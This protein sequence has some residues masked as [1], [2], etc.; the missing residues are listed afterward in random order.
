MVKLEIN[1]E[2]KE[3]LCVIFSCIAVWFAVWAFSGQFPWAANPYNSYVLQAKAWLSGHTDLGRNYDYL[4]LAIYKGKYFVSFPPI[5]SVLVLPFV[6]AH[7][8]D[9][10]AELLISL[11]SAV[12]VLKLCRKCNAQNPIFWTLFLLLGTNVLTVS[13]S[14]WVWFIAQNAAFLFTVMSIYYAAEKRSVPSLLC[15]A[16]A[17]GCRPFQIVYL[18]LLLYIMEI[19]SVNQLLHSLILPAIIAAAY[20]LYNYIRFDSVF[21]FGHNYLPEFTEAEHGQ[22]HISYMAEN[23]KSLI[24]LPHFASDGRL[25][26]PQFN[27]MSVFLCF[28]IIFSCIF[29][30]P[31]DKKAALLGIITAAVQ[32]ALITS[33]RTMGGFHFGNRYCIDVMPC[34][35]YMLLSAKNTRPSYI[36]YP[37]FLFG[38]AINAVGITLMF[39]NA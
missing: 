26:F 35:F 21:E 8:P 15:W 23:L 12:Y 16:L 14:P 39:L 18:P 29:R 1:K 38:L 9:G 33:H 6:L 13:V 32:L 25:V 10:F 2:K 31:S 17:I 22:F 5:P 24:R 30:T 27:G 7:I 4:E 28:P 36:E 3:M 11:L 34:I 19:K 37:L 20:M